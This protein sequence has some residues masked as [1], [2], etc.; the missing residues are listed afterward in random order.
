MSVFETIISLLIQFAP[1]E[2]AAVLAIV[3]AIK[4]FR[5][6][7]TTAEQATAAATQA[8]GLLM[9]RMGNVDAEAAGTNAAVDADAAK[10]FAP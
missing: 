1:E 5:D 2:K 7:T 4:N 8:L 9:G 10:K 3:E 6:K